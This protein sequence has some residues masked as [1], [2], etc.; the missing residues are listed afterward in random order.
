MP[1]PKADEKKEEELD[2]INAGS[3]PPNDEN[4][5]DPNPQKAD[6][7]DQAA[8]GLYYFSANEKAYRVFDPDS[9]AWLTQ[10]E[11]PSEAQI[12]EIK[13]KAAEKKNANAQE[14]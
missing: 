7:N 11:K 6:D 14:G 8:D 3:D 9:S 4:D 1:K 2:E 13:A 10:E 12:A 5:K